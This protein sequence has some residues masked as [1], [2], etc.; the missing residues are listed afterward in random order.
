MADG[1]APLPKGQQTLSRDIG[2]D[3]WAA[4]QSHLPPGKNLYPPQKEAI[5]A[6]LT[7]RSVVVSVPT[8]AGKSVVAYAAILRAVLLGGTAVYLCPLKA[9]A[10]EKREDLE[11][12]ESFG[13]KTT[14]R[15]GDNRQDR[16]A[17]DLR[18]CNV[19][20][21]TN[22][23]FDALLRNRNR[24]AESV[25]VVIADEF[26][27]MSEEGR[28]PTLEV[29]LTMLRSLNP[30]TQVVALSATVA[31]AE[32]MAGWLEAKLVQSDFRPAHLYKGVCIKPRPKRPGARR[33]YSD[34]DEEDPDYIPEVDFEEDGKK[35]VGEEPG[36][37]EHSLVRS[38]LRDGGQVLI[39]VGSRRECPST[40][41][42]LATVVAPR[43]TNPEREALAQAAEEL[44]GLDDEGE[45]TER[46]TKAMLGGAAFHNAS[47][48]ATERKVV[49]REFRA[50]NLKVIVA[51]TTLAAGVN[52][53]ARVVI[54]RQHKR[55]A[56]EGWVPIAVREIHQMCG[57]AGRPGLDPEG[58]AILFA[59]DED[60]AEDVR[61][62]YFRSPP[63]P[64]ASALANQRVLRHHVL[65]LVVAGMGATT[66]KLIEFFGRTYYGFSVGVDEL[67]DEVNDAAA[68]LLRHHLIEGDPSSRL[69]AT[70]FGREMARMYVDPDSAVAVRALVKK[71]PLVRDD[72]TDNSFFAGMACVAGLYAGVE[73]AIRVQ[74]DAAERI[75]EEQKHRL[76]LLPDEPDV[77]EVMP[78]TEGVGKAIVCAA[79]FENW[80]NEV[81]RRAVGLS[82]GDLMSLKDALSH[83]IG[84]ALICRRLDRPA[85]DAVGRYLNEMDWRVD[86]GIKRELLSLATVRK[87]GRVRA[88]AL[89]NDGI[90]HRE[91]LARDVKERVAR[92]WQADA[93]RRLEA[94]ATSDWKKGR[95]GKHGS[96][97]SKGPPLN[98]KDAEQ[99]IEDAKRPYRD[100]FGGG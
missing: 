47:L 59:Y 38:V 48:D 46:L 43:L 71:L 9:L 58:E 32:E 10:E 6:V 86:M 44:G 7:G 69:D 50:R 37:A 28:G 57:R 23:A 65:G 29:V 88:R 42:R 96:G 68:F 36:E 24:W 34:D 98:L 21:C 75:F 97:P 85:D 19:L 39:F 15:T 30:A 14:L 89:F 55:R 54:I 35:R 76:F 94:R 77:A 84:A 51:T 45:E 22:E 67:R 90:R 66:D 40:A 1:V 72:M 63:E 64:I 92:V 73:R 33:S 5:E 31:N 17:R 25:S 13:L 74:E 41:E 2:A 83:L 100:P 81:E 87:V 93:R 56:S 99:A 18:E 70:Q 95:I 79:A 8:S 80:V 78:T 4:V 3:V 62:R 27:L 61:E 12:F 53:P 52:L 49:E 20:V 11:R 60:E 16:R 82:A 26:H 91:D